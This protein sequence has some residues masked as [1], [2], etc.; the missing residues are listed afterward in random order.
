MRSNGLGCFTASASVAAIITITAIVGLTLLSGNSMFS[1]GP[2][3]AQA[4]PA[5]G[6]FTSHAETGGECGLC[7]APIWSFKKMSARCMDCHTDILEQTA[8]LSSMHGA[9][10]NADA[11]FECRNCHPEHQGAE[12]PLTILDI[13]TFPHTALGFSLKGHTT[14]SDGNRFECSD[15]HGQDISVFDPANCET[16]HRQMDVVFTQAHILWVGTDCRACHDGVDSYGDTFDHQ[17]TDFGLTGKHTE[18]L[19]S[20]CHI[21]AHSADDLQNTPTDCAGCHL[22]NDPHAGRFGASCEGCHTTDGWKPADFDHSLVVFK[23]EGKHADVACED[24][25]VNGVYQGT[26]A[27]CFSCHKEKDKHDGRFGADCSAC[28]NPSGWGDVDFDHNLAAFKL[29]GAHQSVQCEDCHKNNVF[30]G[31]PKDCYSCHQKDD[32]H[33]GQFGKDCGTCHSTSTWKGA[34]FDHNK[35]GFP[36]VGSHTNVACE[37][38][39]VGGKFKGTPQT[40]YACHK[41]EDKH[42]GQFGTDCGTCHK[43]TR[44]SDATFDHNKSGFPLVGSHA[45]VACEKCHVGGKFKGTPQTCYACHKQDDKHK[46]ANG[47]DCG[48]CHKPTRWSDATFDH[49][50]SSF[51]LVG[52]HAKVAC[53]K[54]HSGG[55]FQGTPQNCYACHKGDDKHKGQFGTNCASCHSP[56]GWGGANFNHNK[57]KFPL[58]GK[59][60]KVKCDSCHKNGKFAGTPMI[61]YACHKNDDKHK[62]NNGTNCGQCHNPSGWG[63]TNFNHNKTGFPLEGKHAKASCEKCHKNGKFQGTP[64]DC[65]ACHKNDDEHNGKKGTNCGKC[66]NPKGWD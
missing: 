43:P 63:D 19:C 64:N 48:A 51:P 58:D 23:L 29:T 28:H 53:E 38:C 52:K 47:T 11:S 3:N 35:S 37:K 24:C 40:C 31:T 59:H 39:H 60:A 32:N 16:C 1:P 65:Y 9:I 10:Q 57:T 55:K 20:T 13:E 50:K 12:A 30:Q 36:L 2:L 44:W 15:C 46:G 18:V 14:R 66:H 21:D 54:C 42:N 7:H 34:T 56:N 8:D 62:G 25:H 4:G 27:D 26:P 6:G 22:D 49:S 41:Q 17:N 45:N 61:C 33:N 5:L